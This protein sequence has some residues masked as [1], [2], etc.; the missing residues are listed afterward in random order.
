MDIS[1]NI[2]T[3]EWECHGVGCCGHSC[4]MP[5]PKLLAAFED[6]RTRTGGV[7]ITITS[8]FRCNTHNAATPGA[9]LVS[10]HTFARA[11]DLVHPTLTNEQ[12]GAIAELI[13]AFAQGGIGVEGCVVNGRKVTWLHVDIGPQRRFTK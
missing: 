10:Q 12:L 7:P 11:L 1:E 3:D 6:L 13:P 9:A 5:D 2:S 8:G 4:P